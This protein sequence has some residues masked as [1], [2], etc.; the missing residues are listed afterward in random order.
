MSNPIVSTTGQQSITTCPQNPSSEHAALPKEDSKR[1]SADTAHKVGK[2]FLGL[3]GAAASLAIGGALTIAAFNSWPFL[4]TCASVIAIAAILF[5][6][7]LAPAVVGLLLGPITTATATLCA[8]GYCLEQGG[9]KDIGES[10]KESATKNAT[11][12]KA[13]VEDGID[14]VKSGIG[15]VRK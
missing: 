11:S 14:Y 13:Y 15:G 8:V 12:A 3:A 1:L 7:E 9:F 5:P 2:A 10:V 4:I 6:D